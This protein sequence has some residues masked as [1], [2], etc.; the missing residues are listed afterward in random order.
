MPSQPVLLSRIDRFE[1][2]MSSGREVD[3]L[4]IGASVDDSQLSDA[5]R[6]L[7]EA[8][9]LISTHDPH[10]YRHLLR[11]LSRIWVRLLPNAR[12]NYN[13]AARACQLDTRFVL[14]QTVSITEIACSIIHE[15]AHARLE[16]RGIQYQEALRHRID[17]FVGDRS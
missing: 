12:A 10:R 8:L 13:R 9:G 16:H 4:W 2:A 17:R 6:R 15:A 5:L 11:D 1:L 7:E 14:D 3:G